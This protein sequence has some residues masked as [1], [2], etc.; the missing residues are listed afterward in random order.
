MF[1]RAFLKAVGLEQIPLAQ[2]GSSGEDQ[3]A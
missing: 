2:E 1:L 3:K